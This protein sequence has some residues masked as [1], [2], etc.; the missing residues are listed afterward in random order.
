AVQQF[1]NEAANEWSRLEVF[2]SGKMLAPATEQGKIPA[3]PQAAA[4]P[5]VQSPPAPT[6]PSA[7]CPYRLEWEMRRS[8]AGPYFVFAVT[9]TVDELIVN[10]LVVD[11]GNN[12][13]F[14]D[15]SEVSALVFGREMPKVVY[16]KKLKFSQRF[17]FVV[18]QKPIELVFHTNHGVWT[19]K[20]D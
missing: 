8:K 6:K 2:S 12:V 20:I 5:K 4:N 16:P 7:T 13:V 15:F 18:V 1:W 9:S 17:L 3:S 14:N 19:T 11:R 10:N